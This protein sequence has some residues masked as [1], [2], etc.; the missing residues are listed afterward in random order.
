M[1]VVDACLTEKGRKQASA[2]QERAR[3]TGVEVVV[4]STLTRAMQTALIAFEHLV[5]GDATKVPFIAHEDCVER[6]GLQGCNKR[7]PLSILRK[8]F[9]A[10]D[11]TSTIV[12]EHGPWNDTDFESE[13]DMSERVLRF[14]TWLRDRP[15]KET[16]VVCH[17]WVL[18]R[19]FN[20]VLECSDSSLLADF[21][22]GEL[23]SVDLSFELQ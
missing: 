13:D 12:S 20:D 21:E 1:G 4:V 2:V 14:V 8:E 5:E 23:R 17:Y 22:T 18:K 16:A 3:A 7:R 9:L 11:F 6:M 19:L 15:E 10:N